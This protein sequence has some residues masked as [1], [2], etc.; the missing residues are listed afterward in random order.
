[1]EPQW[2]EQ[3]ELAQLPEFL[4][5]QLLPC[6]WTLHVWTGIRCSW[7]PTC[8]WIAQWSHRTWE[9]RARIFG[10]SPVRARYARRCSTWSPEDEEQRM[11]SGDN[12]NKASF[13]RTASK[14][15]HWSQCWRK[16]VKR[17]VWTTSWSWCCVALWQ[18]TQCSSLLLLLFN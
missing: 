13:L 6:F 15:L 16:D 12:N 11:R 18:V 9:R 5:R 1:M 2:Y 10:G 8:L 3:Q 7:S 17:W 4:S 14:S